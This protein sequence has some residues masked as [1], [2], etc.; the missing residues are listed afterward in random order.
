MTTVLND[1]QL[2][3]IKHRAELGIATQQDCLDLISFI[4]SQPGEDIF[5]RLGDTIEESMADCIDFGAAASQVVSCVKKR[6]G[7][8]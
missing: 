6:M 4:D 1:I 2:A 3:S 7:V 8:K 5:D